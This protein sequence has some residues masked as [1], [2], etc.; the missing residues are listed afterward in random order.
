[1]AGIPPAACILINPWPVSLLM[2]ET[3]ASSHG[4]TRAALSLTPTSSILAKRLGRLCRR[5]SSC[6]LRSASRMRSLTPQWPSP[7]VRILAIRHPIPSFLGS[8]PQSRPS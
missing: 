8:H 1:M 2:I 5:A 6:Y 4:S 3:A 7:S